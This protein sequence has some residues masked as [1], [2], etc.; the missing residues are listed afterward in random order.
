MAPSKALGRRPLD[1]GRADL[2]ALGASSLTGWPPAGLPFSY[3]A[4]RCTESSSPA[5]DTHPGAIPAG[6]ESQAVSGAWSEAILGALAMA[7][8]ATCN[9]ADADAFRGCARA[10]A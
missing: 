3:A 2:Y 9:A 10:R 5:A 4:A 7:A 8:R 1:F 6:A